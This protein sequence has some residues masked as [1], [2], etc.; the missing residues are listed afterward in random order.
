[1]AGKAARLA[2]W[3]GHSVAAHETLG[4]DLRALTDGAVISR[5]L[6]R[7]YGDSSLPPADRPEAVNTTR[8]DRL[9]G[10][11]PA[12]GRLRAEAGLSLLEMNR[13]LLP[14]GWF[15]PVTPGTQFVTLGGMVAA[16]VHG[17]NQHVAGNIGHHVTRLE[18]RVA[19]GRVLW[20]SP[21]E[22]EDLFRATIGGMGLTG[23][24]LQV[25]LTMVRIPSRWIWQVTERAVDI[26]AF[27]A[28]LARA[29]REWPMTMGWI[30]CV[31]G[32]DAL[33][34]G[35]LI[36]GRWAEPHEA[37]AHPPRTLPRPRLPIDF[38][39]WVLSPVTMRVFN[40]LIYRKP[41]SAQAVVDPKSFFYPLDAI[42]DWNRMYGKPG[43]T[44]WQGLIPRAAGKGAARRILEVLSRRGA[45]SF[46][47]VIKDCDRDGVG[48]LSFPGKGITIALDIPMRDNTQ[49]V[50]D[51]LNETLIDLGGRIYLAKD[52][53][54]RPEHFRAMEGPRLDEFERIR[55]R[56]DPHRR[57]R[58]A[59]SERL[60]L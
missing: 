5:G 15:T 3:G 29:A 46:L 10:F 51:E 59:Q 39:R 26:D 35:V 17:K 20:C 25:E 45:A 27:E 43:F 24:I 1:M 21:D 52:S 36:A 13:L 4:E 42:R 2:G 9:L 50:I 12:T 16:D 49:A 6:G 23:H 57:L 38:P 55:R 40:E 8:A 19:D 18:M 7:S 53:L 28:T 48:V 34:R 58:S 41:W 32:G 14:R 30:D 56:W 60:G 44:Q 11:D 22:N 31:S 37:P 54:T 47:T 33:G